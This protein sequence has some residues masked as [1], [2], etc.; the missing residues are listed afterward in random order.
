MKD[1][2]KKARSYEGKNK[3]RKTLVRWLDA[4]IEDWDREV[5]RGREASEEVSGRNTQRLSGG[6]T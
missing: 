4:R 1:E 5:T 3:N 2:L 6:K